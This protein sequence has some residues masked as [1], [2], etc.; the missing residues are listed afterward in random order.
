MTL[1]EVGKDRDVLRD[2]NSQLKYHINDLKVSMPALKE[3]PIS[4]SYRAETA[5]NQTQ[6]LTK[7]K[8]V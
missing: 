3:I 2:L 1:D 5:G 8:W 7:A 4:Y 6:S